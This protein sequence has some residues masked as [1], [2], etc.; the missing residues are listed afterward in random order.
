[1]KVL[2]LTSDS[3]KLS[4]DEKTAAVWHDADV[5]CRREAVLWFEGERVCAR[6]VDGDRRE[7]MLETVE[8]SSRLGNIPRRI[9]FPDGVSLAV[10]DNDFIDAALRRCRKPAA[11]LHRLES[12][13]RWLFT[14]AAAAIATVFVFVNWGVPTAADALARATPPEILR[15]ISDEV[16]QNFISFNI[17]KDSRLD[18]ET[19]KRANEIFAEVL[20]D[21]GGGGDYRMRL[22]L[23]RIGFGGNKDSDEANAFA[24]PDGLIVAGDRL[25][26][27]LSD[28]EF[29]AVMAHEIGHVHGRHGMRSFLQSV[30]LF[31]FISFAF[32]DPSFLLAGG[33]GLLNLKYSRGFEREADCFAYHYTVRNNLPA[34]LIGDALQKMELAM[35]SNPVVGDI[36]EKEDEQHA[37]RDENDDKIE[38]ESKTWNMS[39]MYC[40]PIRPPKRVLI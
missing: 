12:R 29:A 40:P 9:V 4:V 2:I 27:I 24:L 10:E 20:A 33:V 22:K 19:V 30:G 15:N 13:W 35:Q 8:I 28:E 5:S 1:M 26:K 18:K 3:S 23:H 32:G 17:L 36:G 16:Y 37:K 34:T 7:A 39:W 21:I 6:N 38:G 25:L 14:I 31:A 11:L